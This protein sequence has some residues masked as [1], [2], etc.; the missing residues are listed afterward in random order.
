MARISIYGPPF[1]YISY[2]LIRDVVFVCPWNSVYILLIYLQAKY[3]KER[4][5]KSIKKSHSPSDNY[6]QL[7]LM[8]PAIK[9]CV[10]KLSRKRKIKLTLILMTQQTHNVVTTS[11]QRRDVAATL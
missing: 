4:A 2:I 10:I 1:K 3:N 11:L 5:Y 7:R 9:V 8:K 6:L